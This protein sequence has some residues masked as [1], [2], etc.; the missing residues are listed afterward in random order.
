MFVYESTNYKTL[1]KDSITGKNVIEFC[2]S[3]LNYNNLKDIDDTDDI[4][5]TVKF[6]DKDGNIM[7]EISEDG[8]TFAL[9][10]ETDNETDK[11]KEESQK[12]W[13]LSHTKVYTIEFNNPCRLG[14]GIW[15]EEYEENNSED[16]E[17]ANDA[18]DEEVEENNNT[19][20]A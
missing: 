17:D 12:F 1:E 11:L 3:M 10:G 16:E 15:D 20:G 4:E 5:Y 8:L 18:D 7:C 9:N 6:V 19:I 2:A 13:E 14:D